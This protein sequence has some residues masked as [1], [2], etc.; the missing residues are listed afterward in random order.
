MKLNFANCRRNN[1]HALIICPPHCEAAPPM[2]PVL[3]L[4]RAA[5][6]GA[7]ALVWLYAEAIDSLI[8]ST[9]QWL[10]EQWW[11]KVRI[12]DSAHESL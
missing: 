4:L 1:T 5:T 3:V 9:W 10:R 7:L 2:D 11:Y 12:G 8:A 6:V